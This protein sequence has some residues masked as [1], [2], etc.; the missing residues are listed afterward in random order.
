MDVE[1]DRG[2]VGRDKTGEVE[3]GNRLLWVLVVVTVTAEAASV[4]WWCR[5]WLLASELASV[6]ASALS[7]LLASALSSVLAS[8]QSSGGSKAVGDAGGLLQ[9]L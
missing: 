7:S 8:A 3:D 2:E 6:L 9:V 5:W 4:G 1:V